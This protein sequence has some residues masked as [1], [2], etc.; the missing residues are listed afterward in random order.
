MSKFDLNKNKYILIFISILCVGLLAFIYIKVLNTTDKNT[1][2]AVSVPKPTATNSEAV[3]PAAPDSNAMTM[4]E[5]IA[6]AYK[7]AKKWSND[8]KLIKIISTD[9]M[10]NPINKSGELGK[11]NTWNIK[12]TDIKSTHEYIIFVSNG[13]IAKHEQTEFGE[14]KIIKDSDLT[15][16]SSDA[17]SIAINQ[18]KLKPGIDWAIGYH[19]N[20]EY[21]SFYD[22]PGKEYLIIEVIG[23]SPKGNFA[24]VDIDEKTGE[25]IYAGEKTYDDKGN[26]IWTD[27]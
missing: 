3:T 13:K 8:A 4:K 22:K 10:D 20:L 6:I 5:A 19:F 1:N 21:A 16:D 11:R 17:L 25:I 15:L 27:F 24:H 26:A 18:K 9:A 7:D 12:F 14:K 23:L 2:A